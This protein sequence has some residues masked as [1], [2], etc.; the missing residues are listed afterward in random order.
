MIE[1]FSTFSAIVASIFIEAMPFL[2]LGALLSAVIEVYVSADRLVAY[3]PKSIA[4]SI[5]AGLG[6][7]MILP[8]CECGVVPIVRRL[9]SKGVPVPAAM[10]FML[11]APVVN[12]VVLISTTVAFQGNVPMI[13]GRIIIVALVASV[14]ALS[15]YSIGDILLSNSASNG[16]NDGGFHHG[17]DHASGLAGEGIR[18]IADVLRHGA[19]EFIDMGK[20][21]ILGAVAAGFFKTYLP[22][23]VLLFFD[24]APILEIVG[25]MGLAVLLSVCS[26]ADAFVAASFV[27]FS[28]ASK[29]AFVTLGPM[30]DLKLLGM[31]A[32]TFSRKFFW[33][34]MILP[35]TLILILCMVYGMI[36]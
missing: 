6:A 28:A 29:V 34:L 32:A 24:G 20:Y 19:H 11:S 26:E 17:H 36:W 14:V 2:A 16:G 23:D 18:G 5:A 1:S 15:A 33:V 7:G 3:L 9:I 21:L 22:Q 31:Y 27:A 30:I 13:A 25:M 8:T 4:G 35:T 10:A 12:P